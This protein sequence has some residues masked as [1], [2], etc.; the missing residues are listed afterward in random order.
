MRAAAATLLAVLLAC[1]AA[2]AQVGLPWPGPGTPNGGGACVSYTGPGDLVSGAVAWWGIRGYAC[3]NTSGST[4]AINIKRASDSETCDV[5]I[6]SSG[7][8]GNTTGCSGADN[9]VSTVTFC[10]ATTCTIP[11]WYD[12]SGNG[13]DVTN[14]SAGTATLTPSATIASQLVTVST[15]GYC[16]AATLSVP[17]IVSFSYVHKLSSGSGGLQTAAG[18]DPTPTQVGVDTNGTQVF[19]YAGTLQ[20]HSGINS[21]IWHANQSILNGSSSQISLDGTA[22]TGLAPGAGSSTARVLCFL[23]ADTADTLVFNG[24]QVR[25]MGIWPNAAA[26]TFLTNL[27]NL[28]SNQHT[29]WGF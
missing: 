24:G 13:R 26:A 28:N 4:K 17:Q 15:S 29:Y 5:L 18:L 6:N 20:E 19:V 2:I 23:A 3:A 1:T 9:G 7:Q 8:L 21:T 12:Q 16:T 27:S 14:N 22:F 25:E 11:K 10:N